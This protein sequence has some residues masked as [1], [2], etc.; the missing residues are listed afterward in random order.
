MGRCEESNLMNYHGIKKCRAISFIEIYVCVYDLVD[1]K[2][3][4][5]QVEYTP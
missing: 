2:R 1:E 3:H 5:F 4:E